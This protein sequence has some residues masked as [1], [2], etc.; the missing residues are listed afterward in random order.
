MGW[1]IALGIITVLAVLPLGV[2][3]IYD[4]NGPLVRII[5]GPVK[6]QVFPMKK[7]AKPKKEKPKQEKEKK[8][9]PPAAK[10][11]KQKQPQGDPDAKGGSILDFWPFVGLVVDFLGDLRRKLRLDW[12]K[13]HMTMAGDDPCDLAVNYGRANA[14]LAALMSQL[15]RL[16][17][18][19]KQDVHISCDFAADQTTIS[20]RLDLTIT[21]GRIISL[22][23]CYGIRA[24]KTYLSIQKKRKGGADL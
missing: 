17:V 19:K 9:K 4:E 20:A 8:Q 7:K 10:E 2:S 16:F 1:L 13:L 18:I 5:A 15:Q 24:L 14:S 3:V 23:V 12:L 11:K 22:V 21:L 6:I